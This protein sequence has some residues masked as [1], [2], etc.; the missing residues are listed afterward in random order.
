LALVEHLRRLGDELGCSPAQL[1][2]AWVLHQR[3]VTGAIVGMRR[4]ED[5]GGAVAAGRIRLDQRQLA[6]IKTFLADG[7]L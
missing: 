7:N 4:P 6:A 2:L 3:A 5:V 1:A